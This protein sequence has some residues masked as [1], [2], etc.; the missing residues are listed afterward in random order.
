MPTALTL[1][2]MPTVWCL[3]GGVRLLLHFGKHGPVDQCYCYYLLIVLALLCVQFFHSA[4]LLKWPMKG[5]EVITTTF[6]YSKNEDLSV[7]A[8]KLRKALLTGFLL[9]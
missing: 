2:R 7:F 8:L 6:F 1:Q 5:S 4:W 3:G 9:S